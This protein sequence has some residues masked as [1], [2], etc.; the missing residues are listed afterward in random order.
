MTTMTFLAQTAI[1]VANLVA[2]FYGF[3]LVWR[4]LLP[5]LPGPRDADKRLAPYAHYFT[6]PFVAPLAR[7]LHVPDRLV[8]GLWLVAVGAIIVGL[9][10]L[11]SSL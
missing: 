11:S 4:V 10:Q 1:A 2:G 9:N 6:D 7:T 5:I 3:W 8:T